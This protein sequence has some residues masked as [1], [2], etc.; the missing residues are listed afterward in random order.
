MVQQESPIHTDEFGV[1]VTLT[2]TPDEGFFVVTA[3]LGTP[4]HD[5]DLLFDTG[6][7]TSWVKCNSSTDDTS[8]NP[9]LS[10]TSSA[11]SCGT[12]CN[13]SVDYHDGSQSSGF[14]ANDTLSLDALVNK[15]FI[16]GCAEKSVGEFGQA[17]GVLGLGHGYFSLLAQTDTT[18]LSIFCY[19]LPLTDSSTGSLWFGV[20]A[21]E[22]CRPKSPS[23]KPDNNGLTN[24]FV[25]FTGITIGQQ[26]LDF[27]S[28]LPSSSQMNTI[29]DSGTIVTRL[30]M[31][32]YTELRT[33][34]R[35]MMS[36]YV[37]A[38]RTKVLDTCYNLEGHESDW[39]PPEMMLH[40][41][42]TVDV[43]LD[44]SAVILKEGDENPM[45]RVCL[46]F[47][48]NG[49][50]GDLTIIGNKQHRGLKVF[51]DINGKKLAFNTGGCS[52]F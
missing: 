31:A 4:K 21:M 17:V 22:T 15:G 3:G 19:C 52:S 24:Y 16:F 23:A 25:K 51:Y 30:P 49:N 35:G 27:A 5:F 34:F 37:E 46:A 33:A 6:S 43:K 42:D 7:D 47:A 29:I 36:G 8:F 40:F 10:S 45:S 18:L 2:L 9:S 39:S 38:E 50:E 32:V 12:N 41:E 11:V 44:P 48:G 26:R 20:Q 28:L 14:Y 13:Y 1:G